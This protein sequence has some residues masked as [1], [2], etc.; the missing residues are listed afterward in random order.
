MGF[1]FHDLEK[2]TKAIAKQGIDFEPENPVTILLDPKTGRIKY[3]EILEEKAIPAII[4]TKIRQE[5][6][7]MVLDTLKEVAKKIDTVFSIDI[8]N[9]CKNGE[10][11][12]K[13]VFEKRWN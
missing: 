4:E 11:P 8:I 10:I 5:K 3:R 7:I 1:Y 12:I 6:A 2:V 9:K 13:Q